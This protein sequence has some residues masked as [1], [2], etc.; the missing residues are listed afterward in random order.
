MSDIKSEEDPK[1]TKEAQYELLFSSE[2]KHG[3]ASL[4]LMSNQVFNEDPKR[5]LFTLA[6]Y[7]FV[8]KMLEGRKRVLEVGCGDAFAT[9]I[10]QQTV[11]EV[12]ATDFDP[13]FVED[14][15]KRVNPMWPI[16]L[17]VHDFLQGPLDEGFDAA[18]LLDVLEHIPGEDEPT[19]IR[20]IIDSLNPSNGVAIFGM[21]SVESQAFA[22]IQSQMGHVNCKSA[23]EL[24]EV[25][26]E[27]FSYVFIFPMNDEVVHTGFGKMAHYL[28][29]VCCAPRQGGKDF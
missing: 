21:P 7:K 3:R 16:R 13:T 24:R 26:E 19:F 5:L 22:S 9:R 10:V 25:L 20:N 28:F 18:Y 4:G 17:V 15:L 29:A 14:A 1:R 27:F 11:G 12:T 6:R 2:E 23:G 8:A